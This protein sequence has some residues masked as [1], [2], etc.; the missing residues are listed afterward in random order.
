MFLVT[1]T[2][3]TL[4][5]STP[6]SDTDPGVKLM[7]PTVLM[8]TWRGSKVAAPKYGPVDWNRLP[9]NR[10]VV[11]SRFRTP[12]YHVGAPFVP[13]TNMVAKMTSWFWIMLMPQPDSLGFHQMSDRS[14][15]AG[16]ETANNAI[17]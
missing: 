6:V 4:Y 12:P 10:P 14:A 16:A 11:A 7:V 3:P 5:V 15:K 8:A 9:A 2:A 17:M 13:Y 1:L